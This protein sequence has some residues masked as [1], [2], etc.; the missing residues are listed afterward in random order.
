MLA[1][2]LAMILT[3]PPA[4]TN[5]LDAE[6]SVS[7]PLAVDA[8]RLDRLTLELAFDVSPSNDLEIAIGED[9]DGD[10]TLGLLE[11]D[12]TLGC[13]CGMWFASRTD[14]GAVAHEG[15]AAFG[16]RVVRSWTFSK[17]TFGPTW[18]TLRLTRRGT[19][20]TNERAKS[21]RVHHGLK[22]LIR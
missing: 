15:R 9:A 3:F 20:P 7:L 1:S 14:T 13:D 11:A 8:R 2:L 12:L 4:S 6:V 5:A 21:K 22:I 16:E 17:D 18:N 19:G 10:G